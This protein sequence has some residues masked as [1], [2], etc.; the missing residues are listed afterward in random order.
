MCEREIE[1][2][3]ERDCEREREFERESSYLNREE[4]LLVHAHSSHFESPKDN[5]SFLAIFIILI[6]T[7]G[8]V[9][10]TS[11]SSKLTKGTNNLV[12]VPGKPFQPSVT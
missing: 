10:N 4:I 8:R 5:K 9:H 6:R 11:F 3:K 2:E 1:R 12:F 7:T